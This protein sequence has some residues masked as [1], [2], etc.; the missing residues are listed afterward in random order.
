M[1][2]IKTRPTRASVNAFIAAVEHPTR[3]ADCEQLLPL[4]ER[5]TGCKA[6]MWGEAIVGFDQYL[7]T[8]SKGKASYPWMVT[9]FSPRKQNLTLYFMNGFSRYGDLLATLGKHKTS[10]SCLYINKL[11]DVDLAVLESLITRSVADMRAG[12]TCSA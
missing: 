7:Y 2:E 12:H 8:P 4:Y 10:V 6:V 1:S 5:I 11:A 3:R 9:G